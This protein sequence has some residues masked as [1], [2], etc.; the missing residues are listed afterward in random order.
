M[1]CTLIKAP[2]SSLWTPWSS[3]K[4]RYA[5]MSSVP[6]TVCA[7]AAPAFLLLACAGACASG[8]PENNASMQN[9]EQTSR[10]PWPDARQ[11]SPNAQ[12]PATQKRTAPLTIVAPPTNIEEIKQQSRAFIERLKLNPQF[13]NALEETQ[14]RVRERGAA[15]P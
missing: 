14:R 3:R 7:V 9:A 8:E 15:S 13:Q 10:S 5:M 6:W 2:V 11:D 12:A 1:T 4:Y